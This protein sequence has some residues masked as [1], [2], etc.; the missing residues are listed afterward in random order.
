LRSEDHKPLVPDIDK[1]FE[2]G[3]EPTEEEWKL[4]AENFKPKSITERKAE[5][6]TLLKKKKAATILFDQARKKREYRNRKQTGHKSWGRKYNEKRK[7]LYK[8]NK[9]WQEKISDSVMIYEYKK[10]QTRYNTWVNRYRKNYKNRLDEY[11]STFKI[12]ENVYV[13]GFTVQQLRKIGPSS[14]NTFKMFQDENIFPEPI[15]EGLQFQK[16][17]L[18]K[19]PVKFYVL[20]EVIE[21]MSVFDKNRGRIS[22]YTEDKKAYLKKKLWEGM[23]QARKEFDDENKN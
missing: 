11:A 18:S 14:M 15:Y 13:Y 2:E 3:R 16:N 4:W 5:H 23:L 22:W 7:Y 12:G 21:Y 9:E 19:K 1:I 17:K 8:Y 10:T 20:T 6:D